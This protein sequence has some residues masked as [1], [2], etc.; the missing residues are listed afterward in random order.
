MSKLYL[1]IE[2]LPADEKYHDILKMLY[3]KRKEKGKEVGINFEKFFLETSFDGTFGRIFCIAYAIDD[4]PVEIIYND[5]DEKETLKQFWE[6][7]KGQELFIGHNVM[8]FDLKFIYQ[9]SIVNCVKPTIDINFARY[10]NYPIFDTMKEWVK[11][12]NLNIGL[13]S[14]ALA[15]NIPTPK[16]G[17]DGSQV[18]DFYKNGKTKD[19]LEYCKKDVETVRAVYKKMIFEI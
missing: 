2:T 5:G 13:E 19:I 7:V 6:I 16:N 4:N 18:F 9:R 10:R 1:D 3:D 8:E 15:L 14:V 12:S 11:W 17:I